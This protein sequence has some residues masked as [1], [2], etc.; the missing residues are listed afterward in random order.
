MDGILI[1]GA[2]G[3]VIGVNR[4]MCELTGLT[5]EELVGRPL[6]ELFPPAEMLRAPLRV[7]LLEA[8]ETVVT[9][10]LLLRRDGT[11]VPV[12]MSSKRMPDGTYHSFFRD[13]TERRRAA[14]EKVRLQDELRHAQKM[15]AVGRLAGGI[16]HDF[17]NMLMVIGS[18][19]AVALRD[20][21][22]GSRAHRCLTEV[23][24]AGERA[25]ALTRQLLAFSRREAVSPRVLD[26]G[27]LVA[28]VAQMVVGIVGDDVAVDLT[29]PRGLGLVRVDAG[30]VEQA[31][32]NLAMNARDAMP[33]GG[34]L[35]LVLSD[36]ELDDARA[37]ALGLAPGPYVV[38]GVIDN[39][40]GMSDEVR[41]HLYEPFFTTKPPGKGTG[42]GLTMVYGAVKQSG[43]EIEVST[44]LGRGTTFRLF[45]P[46]TAAVRGGE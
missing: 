27:E 40:T 4:R 38:L 13:V 17:N 37:L 33:G 20:L 25:A 43:G 45:F 31:V 34:R 36:V 19:V 29:A 10:R 22:P 39:G 44:R 5:S 11:T 21:E 23:D 26:L 32:L 16:A 2:Q 1:A 18:N 3:R 14:E 24:R 6:R 15:E 12:E 30:L 46:R 9:D 35:Q 42:L 41:Q 8:G 7:D 28:N